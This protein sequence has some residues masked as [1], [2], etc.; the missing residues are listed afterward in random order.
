MKHNT[1]AHR[2]RIAGIVRS[3]LDCFYP[4]RCPIC[5]RVLSPKEKL[6][7]HHCSRNLP[8]VQEPYCM[9]CGK[10]ISSHQKE[11]CAD[12]EGRLHLFDEGRAVFLYEKGV[13]LSINRLK[14][15]NRREYVPFYGECLFGLYREMSSS[16]MAECLVPVPMHPKKRSMRGFDQAELLAASLSRR[17]GLPL[18]D[19]LLVRTRLTESSKKLGRSDRRKNLRGVFTTRSGARIPESVI[20]IDDIYTTGATMDEASLALRAAGVKRIYFLTVCIGRGDA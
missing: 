5:E 20:L 3:V 10:P 14:F 2:A 16:W 18:R 15:N 12:C 4:P 11:L 1:S 7:C 6:I 9:C 13:R 8:F 17:C 19:D